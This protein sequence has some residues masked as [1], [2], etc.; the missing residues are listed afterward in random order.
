MVWMA[1]KTM[2]ICKSDVHDDLMRLKRVILSFLLWAMLIGFEE[3]FVFDIL[4]KVSVS[5]IS[6]YG[7]IF[8]GRLFHHI[9]G[10]HFCAL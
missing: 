10:Y 1:T 6:S 2:K 3:C 9:W 5:L 7:Y 4:L 8:A